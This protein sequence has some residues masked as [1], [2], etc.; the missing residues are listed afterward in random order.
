MDEL[1][2]EGDVWL[3]WYGHLENGGGIAEW[4][5]G[6]QGLSN[7]PLDFHSSQQLTAWLLSNT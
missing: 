6:P 5:V 3:P 2:Q 1:A 4:S 7:D